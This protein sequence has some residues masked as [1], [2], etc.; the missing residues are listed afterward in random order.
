MPRIPLELCGV[1]TPAFPMIA[2]SD[3]VSSA[4]SSMHRPQASSQRATMSVGHWYFKG[5]TSCSWSAPDTEAECSGYPPVPDLVEA[6][7]GLPLTAPNSACCSAV[8]GIHMVTFSFYALPFRVWRG[9]FRV[10]CGLRHWCRLDHGSCSNI[11]HLGP[12]AYPPCLPHRPFVM[13][14]GPGAQNASWPCCPSCPR[15][16]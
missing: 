13:L 1:R 5:S 11:H 6:A 12:T 16:L 10:W 14:A 7:A 2:I 9:L 3:P 15:H 8:C 4:F